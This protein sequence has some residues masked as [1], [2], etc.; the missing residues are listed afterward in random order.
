[1]PSR[2]CPP[3]DP[4]D[5][6]T[7]SRG[8]GFNLRALRGGTAV[9]S[10]VKTEGRESADICHAA[11]QRAA[12]A[13][14]VAGYSERVSHRLRVFLVARDSPER[15]GRLL[16][17]VS[18]SAGIRPF[19]RRPVEFVFAFPDPANMRRSFIPTL[20]LPGGHKRVSHD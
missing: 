4:R 19:R 15:R 7:N 3:G 16:F 8:V 1:M 5:A 10:D 6:E 9:V 18:G 11:M 12:R 13:E 17:F 14:S 20:H 2:V